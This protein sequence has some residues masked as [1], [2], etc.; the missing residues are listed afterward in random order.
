LE[1]YVDT[2]LIDDEAWDDDSPFTEA[3]LEFLLACQELREV[4]DT[5]EKEERGGQGR[6]K[7]ERR[8]KQG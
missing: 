5:S 6:R 7:H 2:G 8:E 4:M 3:F 1:I